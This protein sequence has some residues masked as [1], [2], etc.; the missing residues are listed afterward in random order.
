M[1]QDTNIAAWEHAE[2][3]IN[4]EGVK[5]EDNKEQTFHTIL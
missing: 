3:Y 1:H 2:M 4:H 5:S